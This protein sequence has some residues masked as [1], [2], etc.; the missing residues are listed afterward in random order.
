M[1]QFSPETS[2]ASPAGQKTGIVA[3]LKKHWYVVVLLVLAF[4]YMRSKKQKKQEQ[5][6]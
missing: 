6:K 2:S 4:L 1:A 3:A 5:N